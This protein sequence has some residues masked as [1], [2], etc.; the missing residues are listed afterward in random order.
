MDGQKRIW[1][2]QTEHL[3]A[4]RFEFT[5]LLSLEE[6]KTMADLV[7][8]GGAEDGASVGARGD[9]SA[10]AGAQGKV[11]EKKTSLIST[12]Q[13]V[14]RRRQ[15]GRVIDS[16]YNGLVL[17]VEALEENPGDGRPPLAQSWDGDEMAIYR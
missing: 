9:Q 13:Q 15:N 5:W 8:A 16:P 17:E 4:H 12:L 7:A 6:G 3:D 10:A 11:G 1:L 14:L 2:D